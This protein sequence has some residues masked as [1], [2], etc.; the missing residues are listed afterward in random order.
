MLVGVARKI[1]NLALIGFMGSG[2][3]SVGRLVAEQLRF[4]FVD[5][6]ELAETRAGKS[7]NDIFA[8]SGEPAFRELERGI[9][10]ELASSTRT[11]ISTGGG[12]PVN[13]ENLISLKKHAL[14]VCL[15]A[16]PEKSWERLRNQSNRPLLKGTDPL[17]KI[18]SLLEMREKFYKQADVLLNTEWRSVREVAQ[19]VIH[20]FKVAC[21]DLK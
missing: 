18:R 12:L 2:K 1:S 8:E 20:H 4:H 6:D 7:I 16:S 3:S 15:W 17:G 13:P 10:R 5:T 9:V 11:V 21:S 19:Q 14:V